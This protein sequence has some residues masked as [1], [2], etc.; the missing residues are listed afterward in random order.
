MLIN[1]NQYN[2]VELIKRLYR[3]Y[4]SSHKKQILFAI[5][6]MVIVAAATAT[7][8]WMMQPVLD[9]VFLKKD[10][11]MLF[12]IPIAVFLIGLV[13][14]FASYGQ[15]V[16]M[17]N[18]GQRM[19]ADM[20]INLFSHLMHSDLALFH[21][22]S[23]GRLISRFTNDIMLMRGAV[24]NVFT[25]IAKDFFTMIFLVILMFH[26]ST[27]LALIASIVFPTTILPII[28]LGR[29]MRKASDS[30]QNNL[31]TF[32]AQLDETF[33][34]VRMVKAYGREEH[35]IERAKKTIGNLYRLYIKTS[36]IQAAASPIMELITGATIAAVIWYGGYNVIKGVTTPGAFF[37]F[38]AA[39]L[40]A[41][42][43]A[44]TLVTLNNSLQEGMA[45]ASRLYAVL[46]TKPNI[47]N[48]INA[49]KLKINAG[50]I[51]FE[52]ASFGYSKEITAINDI[53]FDV[54]PNKTVALVGASGSGK[55]TIINLLLRFY[56]VNR[57][58]ITID[59]Q[60]IREVTLASLRGS[61]SL[62]SQDIV[63]FDDTVRANIAYGRPNASEEEIIN[64]A[65]MAA[66]DEFIGELSLGY[67]TMIGP[68][69]VRLSGGQRQRIAIARAFVKNA[70]ILLLDEATSAL[71]NSSER[72]V[73]EAID[74]LMKNRTTLVVA[75]RLTTIQNADIIYVLDHGRIIESGTHQSLLSKE[76]EYY[77]LYSNKEEYTAH[78]SKIEI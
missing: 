67:D 18:A 72:L 76:G 42:K 51:R 29:K 33:Q 57:G 70:P 48:N 31:G 54:P 21:D 27:Q 73:Q 4:I 62:V 52:N 23:S 19:I 56:D 14:A 49:T 16:I 47:Y 24:S 44:K 59:G 6:C 5:F 17:R 66:A 68:S 53:T 22:Q 3:E 65:K 36:R 74:K 20:Q 12:Y 8:A 41:Y 13:S 69:G 77:K 26:Q 58:M 39:M 60:D 40:M 71:D 10:A 43:P 34:G 28:M 61:M 55:S 75:H 37:S 32:T 30:T 63:L 11:K 38:V 50:A 45:A 7:N 46:D 15:T 64:A 35:E 1:A 25:G 78:V 9:E 2:N